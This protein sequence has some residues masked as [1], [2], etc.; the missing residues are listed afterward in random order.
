MMQRLYQDQY[1]S[2]MQEKDIAARFGVNKNT[3]CQLNRKFQETGSHKKTINM[4]AEFIFKFIKAIR[5]VPTRW[6]TMIWMQTEM[7]Q[8]Q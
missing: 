6:F 5:L 8:Y 3:I 2:G 1:Q 7:L 4:T